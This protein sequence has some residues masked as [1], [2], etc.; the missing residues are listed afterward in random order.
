MRFDGA[1]PQHSESGPNALSKAR[2]KIGRAKP[3]KAPRQA[4]HG[5]SSFKPNERANQMQAGEKIA[6]GLLGARGDGLKCLITLKNRSTR[7]RLA[8]NTKLQSCLAFR[9]V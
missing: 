7:L 9:F 8:L 4:N 5:V 3:S 1:E 6:R 2:G